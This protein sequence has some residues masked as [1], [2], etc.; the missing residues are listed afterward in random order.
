MFP[1]N[2][3]VCHAARGRCQEEARRGRRDLLSWT[4][5]VI[6]MLRTASRLRLAKPALQRST[7]AA[8][9]LRSTQ[10]LRVPSSNAD[11]FG[12]LNRGFEALGSELSSNGST[13]L[14]RNPNMS[15]I[16]SAA[17]DGLADARLGDPALYG[18]RP[19]QW[20]TGK[21]P[22]E[23]AGWVTA[24]DGREGHL[25]SLPHLS[26]STASTREQFMDYFDN[27]WTLTEQL[28]ASLQGEATF[29]LQPY[30]Q[31]RESRALA[32]PTR[33]DAEKARR[34]ASRQAQPASPAPRPLPSA[35]PL[36]A[37]PCVRTMLPRQAI[38]SSFTMATSPLST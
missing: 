35:L 37:C 12:G 13:G 25:T 34:P 22:A 2:S 1:C 15:I 6:S 21:A 5:V 24:A 10:P 14:T 17:A 23:A 32:S 29:Y 27:T 19:A 31:L 28:F 11:I 18:P 20:W 26:L 3:E 16:G 4:Y 33:T 36:T 8:A 30:H 7:A 38:P 9:R